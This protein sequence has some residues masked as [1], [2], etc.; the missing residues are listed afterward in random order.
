M[1]FHYDT[2]YQFSQVNDK[3]HTLFW[4]RASSVGTLRSL[5]V[6]STSCCTSGHIGALWES[7]CFH[8]DKKNITL[9]F[10]EMG[11]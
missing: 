6:T 10:S 8:L 9:I 1:N 4:V 5:P 2:T 7:S 3:K 11:Q